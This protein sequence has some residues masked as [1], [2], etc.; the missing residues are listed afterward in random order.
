[1][2][3]SRKDNHYALVFQD[4]LTKWPEV[5]AAED[6]KIITV[7]H[8]LTYFTWWHGVPIKIIHDQ[9]AEFVPYV[10]Q[11]IAE[12]L[13]VTQLPIKLSNRCCLR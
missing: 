5:Y 3:L 4:Y 11:E 8:C 7:A 13:R 9:V 1:M 12:I 6:R 2:D 10:L